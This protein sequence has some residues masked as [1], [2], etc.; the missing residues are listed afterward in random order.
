MAKLKQS[1][2]CHGYPMSFALRNQA[3]AHTEGPDVGQPTSN[4]P[5]HI[6]PAQWLLVQQTCHRLWKSNS[7]SGP[8]IDIALEGS[9]QM[10]IGN[11]RPLAWHWP[12]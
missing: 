7:S 12:Q 2:K 6:W 5:N 11:R 9:E 4:R 1:D 3:G 10:E 8:H